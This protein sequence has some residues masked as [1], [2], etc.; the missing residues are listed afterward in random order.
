[1]PFSDFR[2]WSGLALVLENND[3][4]I[5]TDMLTSL[6]RREVDIFNPIF[7]AGVYLDNNGS[8]DLL[9]DEQK[10]TAKS[11]IVALA[12]KMKGLPTTDEQSNDA[13]MSISTGDES[14]SESDEEVRM[15]RRKQRNTPHILSSVFDAEAVEI[16]ESDPRSRKR[17]QSGAVKARD[18][19]TQ[20]IQDLEGLR[21]NGVIKK[22]SDVWKAID[23]H[24]PECIKSAARVI[25]AMPP[26]QVS[27]EQLF[28][29]LKILKSDRRN[30]LKAD[31]LDAMLFLRSNRSKN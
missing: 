13:D 14:E 22:K 18:E 28:S 8:V 6:K 3:S 4:I 26:T 17:S 2:K 9:T 19:I 12:L 27:V 30:R 23:E 25:L 29:S 1:M 11:A 5:A 24:Y 7:L 10:A 15:L 20:G 21:G 16:S 31:L